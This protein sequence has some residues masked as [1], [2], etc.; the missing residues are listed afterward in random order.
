MPP[1]DHTILQIASLL[2]PP[3]TQHRHQQQRNPYHYLTQDDLTSCVRVSKAWHTAFTPLLW[4]TFADGT[5][6]QWSVRLQEAVRGNVIE[7]QG[8]EWYLDVYRRHA[9]FIRRLTV[10]HPLIFEALLEYGL[11]V[12]PS[13][14][15]SASALSL[16]STSS[17]VSSLANGLDALVLE[18]K[19]KEEQE[20]EQEQ[21]KQKQEQGKQEQEQREKSWVTQLEHAEIMILWSTI[22]RYFRY[23][24]I[25][26]VKGS[27]SKEDQFGTLMSETEEEEEG[28]EEEGD[29]NS[30]GTT[31]NNS[32]T[33]IDNDNST[34]LNNNDEATSN[35]NDSSIPIAN[36]TDTSIPTK[37]KAAVTLCT[38][39]DV[40]SEAWWRLLLSNT[41]LQS[42]SLRQD[43]LHFRQLSKAR[44]TALGS[45]R[46]VSTQMVQGR[47]PVLPP[48]VLKVEATFGS[49]GSRYSRHDE[50]GPVNESVEEVTVKHIEYLGQLR[51]IFFQAPK[52]RKLVLRDLALKDVLTTMRKEIVLSEQTSIVEAE[53]NK[54][55]LESAEEAEERTAVSSGVQVVICESVRHVGRDG[56]VPFERLFRL[57]P[58]LVEFYNSYWTKEFAAVFAEC[59]PMLE[60]VRIE[61][62]ISSRPLD[63]RPKLPFSD[64]VSS[65]LTACSKL[66]EVDILYE[67]VDTKKVVEKP[68][69]CL[70]LEKLRCQFVGVPYLT[71]KEQA[72]MDQMLA[73]ELKETSNNSLP[74]ADT[75][76]VTTTTTRSAFEE[77]LCERTKR[78]QEV[79]RQVLT[80]LS[81]LPR[82]KHL[83]LS[84]DLKITDFSNADMYA[85]IY[86][87]KKDGLHYINYKDTRPDTL[88]LRLDCGLEQLATLTE[89]EFLAFESM[90]PMMRRE[91]IEWFARHF[92]KLKE[93]RGLA[94]DTHVGVE[95]DQDKSALRELLQALRSDILHTESSALV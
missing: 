43:L 27:H 48:N 19:D 41:N 31:D 2:S 37:V 89:L 11:R 88:H 1:Q 56:P 62:P 69:V 51:Q 36:P 34:T 32:N 83:T 39:D 81:K 95:E 66:K 64:N 53:K 6:N 26:G 60:V 38:T 45:I 73:R 78:A 75:T 46:T 16:S 65:L 59:C 24:P 90:D 76:A 47:L 35:D 93:M 18:D 33:T 70:G 67:Y 55:E 85:L 86:R 77:E 63:R 17:P 15:S 21:G 8:L 42:L 12:S 3:A 74:L 14:L 68:W 94:L 52:L 50:L 28:E 4:H 29:N 71:K 80:Q 92:P 84:P 49:L 9:G 61:Q 79:R 20:Q 13:L 54:E 30:N 72:S 58:K 10:Q 40:I 82:L 5:R 44:P 22:R 91:D 7:G 57:T 23:R 25:P 87:S